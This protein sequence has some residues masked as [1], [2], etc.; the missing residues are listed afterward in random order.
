MLELLCIR[1]NLNINARSV[2]YYV[3]FNNEMLWL[4]C[5]CKYRKALLGV[6]YKK[7]MRD[8]LELL[9]GV[10]MCS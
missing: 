3:F 6:V 1:R 8:E 5:V 9:G 4:C 10:I 2:S 7:G